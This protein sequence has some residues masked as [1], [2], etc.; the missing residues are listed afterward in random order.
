M[1]LKVAKCVS[2]CKCK[3]CESVAD[4]IAVRRGPHCSLFCSECGHFIKHASID[5]KRFLY[6]SKVSVTDETPMKVAM[7]YME[8]KKTMLT[9][10]V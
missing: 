6:V 7:L 1:S 5:D 9:S 4:S 2:A 8:S 3:S 10:K